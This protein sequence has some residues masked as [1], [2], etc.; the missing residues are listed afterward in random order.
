MQSTKLPKT[1]ERQTGF[2]TRHKD[3]QFYVRNI[4]SVSGKLHGKSMG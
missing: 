2:G 4:G 1:F 3:K